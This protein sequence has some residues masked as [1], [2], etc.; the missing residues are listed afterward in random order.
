MPQLNY[1]EAIL[2]LL[3]LIVGLTEFSIKILSKWYRNK[4]KNDP[5]EKK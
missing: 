2:L 5:K 1:Y 4:K 3:V